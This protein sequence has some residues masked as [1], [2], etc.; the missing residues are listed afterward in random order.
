MKSRTLGALALATLALAFLYGN[1]LAGLVRAWWTNDD[2]SHG[3]L[4]APVCAYLVW[5]RRHRLAGLELRP[6]LVG[7]AVVLLSLLVLLTGELGAEMFLTRISLIGVV[8]GSVMFVLGPEHARILALPLGVALLAIPLPAIIF[9]RLAFPLQLMASRVA[10]VALSALSVPVLREGNLI[11]LSTATLE[12][13]EACSGIR[14][15]MSLLTLGIVYGYFTETSIVRR[16]LLAT[17]MVPIAIVANALRVAGTG[18]M[19]H[20]AGSAAA[21]SF[22]HFFAGWLVFMAAVMMLFLLQRLLRLA[23]SSDRTPDLAAGVAP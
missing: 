22:F 23:S 16:V 20:V 10:E 2:Y 1:V 18:F 17:A 5:E 12:V 11:F 21:D 6:S 8:A 13:A 4:V 9:N 14:S 7:L 3:F 19:A 15:L